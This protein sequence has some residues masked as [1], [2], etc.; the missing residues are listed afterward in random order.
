LK[1]LPFSEVELTPDQVN[2]SEDASVPTTIEFDSPIYLNG[3]T[4]Y[5]I[6]LLSDSTEYT[7]WISRLGEADVTSAASEAGQV[8]VSAQPILGSL[9][10][11]QN[12]SS[13]DASQYEDLKFQFSEQVLQL[14][15]DRFS[16][17]IQHYQQLVLMY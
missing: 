8:L 9:F 6:V 16:S 12:A 3:Q 5:A 10:K 4:E 2:I 15:V 17:L 14:Q 7:A 1:I 13:W 11:S